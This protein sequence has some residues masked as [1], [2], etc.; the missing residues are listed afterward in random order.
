MKKDKKITSYR[1]V[2]EKKQYKL[3]YTDHVSS[4]LSFKDL[5]K[6][7]QKKEVKRTI[8]NLAKPDAWE[9]Y[10]KVSDAHSDELDNIV[11]DNTLTIQEAMNKFER[12]LEKI[13]FKV[14][15]KVSVN[16]EKK[17]NKTRI[18]NDNEK[19]NAKK[20]YEEQVETVEAELNRIKETK[21]GMEDKGTSHWRKEKENDANCHYKP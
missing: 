5:P 16:A 21:N 20:I 6:R 19:E 3:T 2:K 1:V 17:N 11:E 12:I 10:G 7:K 14:F 8:W 4:I 18:L 9:T 15:G 13:K